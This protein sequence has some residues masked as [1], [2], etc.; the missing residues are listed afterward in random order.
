MAAECGQVPEGMC[1]LRDDRYRNNINWREGGVYR[2]GGRVCVCM[3]VCV[4][5]GGLKHLYACMDAFLGTISP[6]Y[7]I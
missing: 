7:C 1:T 2:G 3:C 6:I 4:W 5:G